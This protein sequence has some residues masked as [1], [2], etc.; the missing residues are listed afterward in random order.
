MADETSPVRQQLIDM[1]DQRAL[2]CK[3]QRLVVETMIAVAEQATQRRHQ[4]NGRLPTDEESYF[5]DILDALCTA[6][7]TT[8]THSA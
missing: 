2:R 3:M 1:N 7:I 4:C 5:G 8:V 6:F